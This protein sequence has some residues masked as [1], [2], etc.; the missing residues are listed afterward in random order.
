[1]ILQHPGLGA[2]RGVTRGRRLEAK[3]RA[4]R[5]PAPLGGETPVIH[6]SAARSLRREAALVVAVSSENKQTPPPCHQ[7]KHYRLKSIHKLT[8]SKLSKIITLLFPALVNILFYFC[9][10]YVNL[11]LC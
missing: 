11:K 5:A 1:M 4:R 8:N 7:S 10:E 9:I 6:I 3:R 2:P